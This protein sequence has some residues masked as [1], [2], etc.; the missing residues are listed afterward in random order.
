[1]VRRLWGDPVHRIPSSEPRSVSEPFMQGLGIGRGWSGASL[2]VVK[3]TPP[4]PRAL[5]GSWARTGVQCLGDGHWKPSACA[6]RA[7]VILFCRATP[8]DVFYDDG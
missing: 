8:G 2:M 1:M 4:G 3:G 5:Y 6:S 7:P